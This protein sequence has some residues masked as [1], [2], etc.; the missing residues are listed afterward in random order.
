[1]AAGTREEMADRTIAGRGASAT[2]KGREGWGGR[3]GAQRKNTTCF[4]PALGFCMVT[5]FVLFPSFL[6]MSKDHSP[7]F[8]FFC[9]F[10]LLS[11][12]PFRR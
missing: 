7:H 6:L 8:P 12:L 2:D 9:F 1:M 5:V 3:W 11:S 4:S 10:V